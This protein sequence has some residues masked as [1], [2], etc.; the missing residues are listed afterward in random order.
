MPDIGSTNLT[1]IQF[2]QSKA[3]AGDLIIVNATVTAP[4]AGVVLV[5][6]TPPNGR[7]FV[8]LKGKVTG[9]MGNT[10]NHQYYLRNNTTR[11]DSVQSIAAS[12]TGDVGIKNGE[13]S[14]VGDVLVGDGVKTYDIYNVVSTP[15]SVI[16]VTITGYLE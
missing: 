13:F 15:S 7:T 4:G 11:Q 5:S 14:L 10:A 6:Y 2:L 1:D 12:Q 9:Y 16:E 8:L 3:D